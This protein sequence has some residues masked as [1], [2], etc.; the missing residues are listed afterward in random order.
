MDLNCHCYDPTRQFVL[1]KAAW[2]DPAQ[3][4]FG[5]SAAYYSDYRYQRRPSENIGV[6]RQFRYKERV[7]LNI[8]IEFTNV[9]NR[10]RLL[11]PVATNAGAAQTTNAATGATTAG[12]GWIN[13][14]VGGTPATAAQFAR[15]GTL[16]AR[17]TF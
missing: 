11:D 8:R 10:L 1:N 9:L 4:Q 5:T 15:T 2:T 17:F 6:G 3:G 7:G 16:V 14:A 12:F 13:T